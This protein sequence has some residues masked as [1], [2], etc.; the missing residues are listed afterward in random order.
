MNSINGHF[1]KYDGSIGS[2]IHDVGHFCLAERES[3]DYV[4]PYFLT[5]VAMPKWEATINTA[6]LYRVKPSGFTIDN[7]I[8][9]E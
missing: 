3:G 7:I 4:V 2:C 5:W 9:R 8:Y 1:T 6:T